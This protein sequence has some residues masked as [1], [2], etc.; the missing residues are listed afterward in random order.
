MRCR[1]LRVMRDNVC[2]LIFASGWDDID[3]SS[4]CL[5]VVGWSLST[6]NQK[7]ILQTSGWSLTITDHWSGLSRSPMPIIFRLI[8]MFV[9]ASSSYYFACLIGTLGCGITRP[10]ALINTSWGGHSNV[11]SWCD[12][13]CGGHSNVAWCCFGGH[14]VICVLFVYSWLL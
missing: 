9:I 1:F 8:G 2:L 13:S 5:F 14:D 7:K 10:T 11:A 3:L 12:I 4:T 6:F